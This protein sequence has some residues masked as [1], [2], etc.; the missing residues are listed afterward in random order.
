[1]EDKK[2]LA[3]KVAGVIDFDID[4]Q[5]EIIWIGQRSHHTGDF[6]RLSKFYS[7]QVVGLCIEKAREMGW[8]YWQ[9]GKA[10]QFT[11]YLNGDNFSTGMFDIAQRGHIEAIIRAFAEIP[12]EVTNGD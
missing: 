5:D 11:K 1:M 12:M 2:E 3:E 4:M 9:S 6:I 7:W 8:D 10:C